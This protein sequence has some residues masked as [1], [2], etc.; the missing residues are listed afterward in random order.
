MMKVMCSFFW[1]VVY[2]CCSMA[3][4]QDAVDVIPV[5]HPLD[6][7][8]REEIATGAKVLRSADLIDDTALLSSFT[9][10][11]PAKDIVRAWKQGD[12]LPPRQAYVGIRR[13]G[14]TFDAQVDITQ[15]KIIA[16]VERP[17]LHPI[18]LDAIGPGHVMHL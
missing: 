13:G 15:Q 10:L 11:E 6:A 8:T 14:K 17:G 9:L 7:L 18:V 3:L 4:A 12:A 16:V 5:F 1:L 2:A